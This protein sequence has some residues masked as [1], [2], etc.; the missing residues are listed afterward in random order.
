MIEVD[1]KRSLS[2]LLI[3]FVRYENHIEISGS[4]NFDH[5]Q[6]KIVWTFSVPISGIF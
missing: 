1:R 5:A 6:W 2:M 4:I 3:V